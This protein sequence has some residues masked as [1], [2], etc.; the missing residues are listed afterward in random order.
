[1][2]TILLVDVDPATLNTFSDLLKSQSDDLKILTAGNAKEVPNIISSAKVNMIIIDLKMPDNDDLQFLGY[3]SHDFPNIPVIVMTAFGTPEIEARIKALK[4]CQYYQKPVNMNAL[5]EKIFEDLGVGVGGQ[6][7]GIALSS[8][9]QMSEMEKSTCRLKIRSEEGYGYLYLQ[10]G[11]LIAAETGL[12]HSDEAAFEIISWD[13]AVIEIEK[14]GHKKKREIKMPLMNILMEG[15]RIK[16]E[17]E[18]AAKEKEAKNADTTL[19]RKQRAQK[20]AAPKVVAVETEDSTPST[21]PSARDDKKIRAGDK[22]GRAAKAPKKNRWLAVVSGLL[23]SVAVIVGGG[24]LWIQ[25][26]QPRLVKDEFQ[27]V[28]VDVGNSPSLEEKET[29]LQEY[30]DTHNNSKYTLEANRKIKEIFRLIQER[31]YENAVNQ[32]T[33]LPVDKNFKEKAKAIYQAYLDRF[34]DGIRLDDI[35]KKMEEIPIL[36]DENDFQELKQIDPYEYEKRITAYQTYLR[37]HKTGKYQNEVQKLISDISETYYQYVKK[38]ISVCERENDW[39]RCIQLCD[40]YMISYKKSAQLSEIR[41]LRNRMNTTMVMT[42]LRQKA[43]EKSG[44]HPAVR[45]IYMNYLKANPS[46]SAKEEIQRELTDINKMIR[47]KE[48]WEAIA[49]L[50]KNKKINLFERIKT[51][52]KYMARKPEAIYF[53]GAGVL[54]QRLEK[55]KTEFNRLKQIAD[56]QKKMTL[57]NI[58]QEKRERARLQEEKA[59]IG[60]ILSRSNGRF[61]VNIDGTVTD[62]HTGLVWYILDSHTELKECLNHDAA[63]KYVKNL[64]VGGYKDWRLPSANDLMA[65]MNAKN[66]FPRSGAKWYWTSELFW[67]GYYEFGHTVINRNGDIW[68]KDEAELTQCGAVRAVRQ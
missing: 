22:A 1:M 47:E 40:K 24:M 39:D 43:S 45:D 58:A 59:K 14:T 63:E 16:D 38:E 44:D 17:K 46:S 68:V 12:L 53:Q 18:A 33:N 50:S 2:N 28:L 64:E 65:V 48:A 36:V 30:I 27:K 21:I 8:F 61:I 6:I 35:K 62:Q 23:I 4:T 57:E 54:M 37:E 29:L 56:E 42:D 15:L 20:S 25:V 51:L 60:S 31:D 32:V 7:H 66:S 55:E 41:S 26:I 19:E 11:E 34:S 3:M 52:E 49:K 10:K 9:L 67:K 13:N 5:S